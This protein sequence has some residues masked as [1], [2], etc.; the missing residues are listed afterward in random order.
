MEEFELQGTAGQP[1]S[2]PISPGP[3]TGYRWQLRLPAGVQRL[4]DAP[5][6][7]VPAGTN[8]GASL[9]GAIRVVAATPGTYTIDGQLVRP[10]DEE[11][12]ARTVRL[13]LHIQ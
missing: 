4:E 3:A 6:P 12:V 9:A 2:L 1:V 5:G 13:H 8:L 11:D 10:W 7:E